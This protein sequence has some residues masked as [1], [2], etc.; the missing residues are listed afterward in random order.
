MNGEDFLRVGGE[1]RS[2]QERITRLIINL[3]RQTWA[4][5]KI[6]DL[7]VELETVNAELAELHASFRD[8]P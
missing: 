6:V 7:R 8:G 5:Q 4:K 1:L 2:R 3:R